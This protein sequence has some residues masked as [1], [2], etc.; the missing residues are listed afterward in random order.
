VAA[1]GTATAADNS[2]LSMSPDGTYTFADG[3][4]KAANWVD[5][6]PQSWNES[7]RKPPLMAF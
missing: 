2:P 4:A 5:S 3:Q 7:R 6:S 1:A